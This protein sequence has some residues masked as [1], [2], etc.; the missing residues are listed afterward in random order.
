[1][2]NTRKRPRQDPVSCSFC[3]SKKLKCDRRSPCSNCAT[4]QITCDAPF[5]LRT[6]G[7]DSYNDHRNETFKYS[8]SATDSGDHIINQRNHEQPILARLK[9]LEDAVFGNP[10]YNAIQGATDKVSNAVANE[11]SPSNCTPASEYEDVINQLEG[12]V[13]REGSTNGRGLDIR[14]APIKLI[15]SQD[16]LMASIAGSLLLPVR[17]QAML[18]LEHYCAYATPLQHVIHVPTVRSMAATCYSQLEH[19]LPVAPAQVALLLAIFTASAAMCTY[20][21]G[22]TSMP[23]TSIDAQRV[24]PL[25]TNSAFDTIEYARRTASRCIEEI[26]ALQIL[27]FLLFHTEGFSTRAR[28]AFTSAVSMSRDLQLHKLDLVANKPGTSE[29]DSLAKEVKRRV[30]WHVV[31]SDWLIALSGGPQEGT[32]LVQPRH[33]RANK[34]R[35]VHDED[36][37]REDAATIDRPLSEPT[38]VSHTLLTLPARCGRR[39]PA[40]QILDDCLPRPGDMLLTAQEIL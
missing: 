6:P 20:F 36:L 10:E 24:Y 18:L 29:H 11:F 38:I 40:A 26:Q 13:V 14:F 9:R 25:W 8:G 5:A 33:I 4:R 31:A 16:E 34:P 35:N 39:A 19:G 12:A 23:F 37:S 21:T 17:Y 32:Y 3:R 22:D 28:C 1:M 7:D 30:W 15:A 27:G 2:P